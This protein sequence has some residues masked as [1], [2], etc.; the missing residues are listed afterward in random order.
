MRG[1]DG[2]LAV[3]PGQASAGMRP[4]ARS[5]GGDAAH[6]QWEKRGWWHLAKMGPSCASTSATSLPQSLEGLGPSFWQARTKF[7]RHGRLVLPATRLLDVS[8][9][10]KGGCG[11]RSAHRHGGRT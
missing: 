6:G 11:G 10:S 3:V 5:A 4:Q 2:R 7:R 9:G 1:V 8:E